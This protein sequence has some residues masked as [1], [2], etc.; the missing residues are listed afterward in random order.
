MGRC[1]VTAGLAVVPDTVDKNEKH[2]V[3]VDVELLQLYVHGVCKVTHAH[4]SAARLT[5]PNSA[6]SHR[7]LVLSRHN[8]TIRTQTGPARKS[9]WVSRY[10]VG[11]W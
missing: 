8:Q 3:N 5:R 7:T 11:W 2:L 6:V 9:L 1:G 4:H 10:H